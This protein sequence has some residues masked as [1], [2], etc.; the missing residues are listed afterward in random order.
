MNNHRDWFLH[1][2]LYYPAIGVR[3]NAHHPVGRLFMDTD[4][5][6]YPHPEISLEAL[7]EDIDSRILQGASR[8]L[9][10][11]EGFA[12]ATK[13]K[14]AAADLMDRFDVQVLAVIR[15]PIRWFNSLANQILKGTW[16]NGMNPTQERLAQR[17]LTHGLRMDHK[18]AIWAEAFG[19]QR[20]SACFLTPQEDFEASFWRAV[21][22][23]PPDDVLTSTSNRSA[24]YD[25]LS[26]IV[27]HRN[28]AVTLPHAQRV[29]IMKWVNA[30]NEVSDDLVPNLLL[31]RYREEMFQ[32]SDEVINEFR[33]RFGATSIP[34]ETDRTIG[35][36]H[37]LSSLDPERILRVSRYVL[38]HTTKSSPHV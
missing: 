37:D 3:F 1:Q 15:E 26:F 2:G 18:L 23:T 36:A 31:D 11:S 22:V 25:T 33:N 35:S 7:L 16:F 13:I 5:K 4:D 19:W 24:R 29:A 34:F 32:V 8:I 6:N 28:W 38:E 20:I 21:D 10:S 9:I 17:F 12:T 30:Y 14:P 27:G